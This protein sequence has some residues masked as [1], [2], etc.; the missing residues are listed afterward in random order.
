M[1]R[2]RYTIAYGWYKEGI[3]YQNA[4]EAFEK[5]S[6][7]L[8]KHNCKLL[9]WASAFGVSESIVYVQE[10]DD[11]HDWEKAGRAG[12]LAF[13]PIDRTR[14]VMGWDYTK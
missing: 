14:T 1:K 5:Y 2:L 8:A 4:V 6:E 12:V 7:E 13:C 11:I 9:F 10:F 3:S